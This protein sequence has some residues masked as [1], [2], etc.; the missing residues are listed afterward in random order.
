MGPCGAVLSIKNAIGPVFRDLP[1][2]PIRI[3]P[4]KLDNNT[5]PPFSILTLNDETAARMA[6]RGRITAYSGAVRAIFPVR[7]GCYLL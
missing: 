5:V 3:G 7:G 1:T 4:T 6:R 2:M